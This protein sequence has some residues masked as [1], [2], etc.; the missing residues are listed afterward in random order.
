VSTATNQARLK[1]PAQSSLGY[2]AIANLSFW[3][4]I[5]F[6]AAGRILQVYPGRLPMLA[7]IAMH[8]VPPIFFTLIHGARF[9][10][11]RGILAFIAITLV[12]GNAFEN[13]GVHTGFPFGHYYFTSVMG[14]KVLVV[15]I[16]LGL[17]YVGMAYLSWTLARLILGGVQVPLA[18]WRVVTLP[19]IA[20]FIMVSW[21]LSQDPIWST[22]LRAWIWPQG[23]P[24]FGVPLTNFFG[25]YL[26]VFVIYLLFALYLRRRTISTKP[27]PAGY[28]RQA[29]LFYGVSA[30]G[31]LLL[32]LP[33]ARFSVVADP[34]GAQWKVSDITGT[35]ALVTIFTMGTFACM[36]WLRLAD[37]KGEAG[38]VRARE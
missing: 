32:V 31:N 9:Y 17:A 28:W 33:Q 34:T 27:L 36:A 15:P 8:V 20:A 38:Q 29:V 3:V 18:G 2:Q 14:P 21:D 11:W 19:L 22:I 25:W 5:T 30:A 4:L 13:L 23:G 26:T 24:Y 37:Q 6:Y 1:E 10:R 7:V 12:V 35:C 16:M